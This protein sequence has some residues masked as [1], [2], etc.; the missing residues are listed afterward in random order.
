MVLFGFCVFCSS[1]L[2]VGGDVCVSLLSGCVSV[3][4]SCCGVGVWG[5]SC[6]LS[7]VSVCLCVFAL[8]DC[9][10]ACRSLSANSRICLSAGLG[11]YV[12]LFVCVLAVMSSL[13]ISWVLIAV[14][15][16]FSG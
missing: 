16:V 3:V 13:G 7:W 8:M 15:P 14:L 12:G 4:L 5:V 9:T 1:S 6:L 2:F 11:L 10:L